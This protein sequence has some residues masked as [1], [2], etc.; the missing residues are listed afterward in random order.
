MAVYRCGNISGDQETAA[1]NRQDFILSV[2]QG[3]SCHQPQV[4]SGDYKQVKVRSILTAPTVS[5][6]FQIE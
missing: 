6:Q 5:K 2:L 3:K 4:I 1:W